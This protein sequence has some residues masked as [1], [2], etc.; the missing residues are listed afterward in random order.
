[1]INREQYMEQMGYKDEDEW[2]AKEFQEAATRRVQSGLVL[3]ELSKL[4]N[5]QV[6]MEE[7][8]ARLNE[9]MQQ[10]PN[11]KEQLDTPESRRDIANRVLTEKTLERLAELN[12]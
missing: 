8:D 10:F 3:S 2:R 12:S 6:T 7:L 5:V 1:M 4:E 11:M 9:M